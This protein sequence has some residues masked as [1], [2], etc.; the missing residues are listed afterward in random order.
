MG[1]VKPVLQ[2]IASAKPELKNIRS[3]KH[4]DLQTNLGKLERGTKK[5]V[6]FLLWLFNI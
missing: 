2:I 5:I 3:V 1:N 4:R 6:K